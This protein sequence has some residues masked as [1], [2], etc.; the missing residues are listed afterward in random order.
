MGMKKVFKV[1]LCLKNS[2]KTDFYVAARDDI[3][4]RSKSVNILKK[5]WDGI[6][7]EFPGVSFAEI[8]LV[9]HLDSL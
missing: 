7:G 6:A 8:E 1:T 4:A 9:C 3:E 2:A 5:M